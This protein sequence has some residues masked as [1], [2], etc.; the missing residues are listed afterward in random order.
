MFNRKMVFGAACMGML[1]FGM[2]MITLGSIIPDLTVKIK[3]DEVSAGT[4]FSILPI[5]ILAGS[6]A[7]GPI[8][9]R[10]G[11]RLLLSISSFLLFAGFEGIAFSNSKALIIFF[12]LIVGFSGG[13]INGATNAV[14]ADISI[15]GKG[16]ALSL[17][18]AFFGFGALG[19]PLVLGLLKNIFRFEV[20][21]ASTG[22]L[23]FAAAIIF[24]M[25]RYPAPKKSKG[26]SSSEIFTL[27]RDKLLIFI[28]IFLFFQSSFEGII[29]NWT[30]TYLIGRLDVRQ[31][32]ALYGLSSYV[33]GMTVMRLATGTILSD[34][35]ES[36]L[37]Y[38]CFGMILTGLVFTTSGNTLYTII[39]GLFILGAGLSAGFPVMLG[40]TGTA[41]AAL[42]GTAFSLILAFALIGNMLMNYCMGLIAKNYGIVHLT[43]VAFGQLIILVSVA[44]IILKT[45]KNNK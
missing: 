8:A 35:K 21:V 4:L 19:M 30:T 44:S 36:R 7:F 17:L 5:G 11:Y 3:L 9:D 27:I 42:S 31:S 22:I 38:I 34:I 15:T 2:A 18:G 28:A 39:P 41:F 1:F 6:L 14:V 16:A 12:I 24:L 37:L 29:N 33:A 10:F 23:T 25:I 32:Y 13:V 20:I 45:L 40:F 26:I 43:T